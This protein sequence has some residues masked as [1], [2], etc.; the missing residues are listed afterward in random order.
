MRTTVFSPGRIYHHNLSS[1]IWEWT[2]R[3]LC[4][5]IYQLMIFGMETARASKTSW[6]EERGKWREHRDVATLGWVRNRVYVWARNFKPGFSKTITLF[7]FLW[8]GSW[9]R[10]IKWLCGTCENRKIAKQWGSVQPSMHIREPWLCSLLGLWP[11]PW[12]LHCEGG[13]GNHCLPLRHIVFVLR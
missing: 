3:G 4:H 8:H 6:A 10:L 12:S 9:W 11:Q 5:L 13:E 7:V 2:V 1:S